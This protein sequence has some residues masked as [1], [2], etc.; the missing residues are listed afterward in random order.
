MIC[1]SGKQCSQESHLQQH[2]LT[3]HKLQLSSTD[4]ADGKEYWFREG[5]GLRFLHE[6]SGAKFKQILRMPNS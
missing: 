3:V 2:K 6:I 1:D 4:H 5:E